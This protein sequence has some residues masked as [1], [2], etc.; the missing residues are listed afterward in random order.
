[1]LIGHTAFKAP[2]GFKK[3]ILYLNTGK[4]LATD[5]A[6]ALTS[7]KTASKIQFE[8]RLYFELSNYWRTASNSNWTFNLK[9]NLFLNRFNNIHIVVC[10]WIQFSRSDTAGQSQRLIKVYRNIKHNFFLPTRPGNSKF[11]FTNNSSQLFFLKLIR[12]NS[13]NSHTTRLREENE[14]HRPALQLRQ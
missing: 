14:N 3:H 7:K 11:T 13:A 1:M 9:P 10:V 8:V 5:I 4:R 12:S 6:W 2:N